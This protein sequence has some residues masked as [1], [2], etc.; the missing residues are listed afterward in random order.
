MGSNLQIKRYGTNCAVI[1]ANHF[2]YSSETTRDFALLICDK[3]ETP[4]WKSIN[5]TGPN[6]NDGWLVQGTV[7]NYQV[8]DPMFLVVSNMTSLYSAFFRAIPYSGP[9]VQLTGKQPNAVVSNTIVLTA[10]ITDLSGVTNEQFQVTVN[11]VPA[12]SSFAAGNAINID[13]RYHPS[14]DEIV[15]LNAFNTGLRVNDPANPPD[16]AKLSFSTLASLPLDFENSTYVGFASDMCSPDVGTNNMIFYVNKAQQITATISNPTNGQTLASYGGYMPYAGNV[17]ISWNFTQSDGRT[18]YGGDSYAVSFNALGSG[19]TT[20]KITNTIDRVGVRAGA[21]TLLT[22]QWEDPDYPGADGHW[23]NDQSDNYIKS[24]L[25]GLYNN[26]YQN[27]S[28]TQYYSWMVGSNRNRGDCY[29]RD[30]WSLNWENIL[31]NLTNSYY[32]DLTLGPAHGSGAEIGGGEGSFLAGTFTPFDLKRY[33]M[34]VGGNNW[35]LRKACLWTCYSGDISLASG[36]GYYNTYWADAC[37]IRPGVQQLNSYMRKNC[38][39]FLIGQINQRGFAGGNGQISAAQVEEMCDQIW[40]CG[41]NM[42]PGGCDP[43][44]SFEFAV[45]ATRGMYYPELEQAGPWLNGYKYMIYA[46]VYDDLL[47]VGNTSLVQT[48]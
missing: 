4:I 39:L 46:S 18:A 45:N 24:T 32:S 5:L 38:G 34:G 3:V 20:L 22:Y 41:K 21:G 19:P 29:P 44:Y 40:V 47:M 17:Q 7:P 48:Q 16:K 26:L 25:V 33:V 12:R 30:S 8:K 42:Y 6:T 31:R 43:T 2:D 15:Y 28:L 9:Q 37:G 23:L 13:T 10:A 11:G 27:W 14:G 35:R 1:K 36:K